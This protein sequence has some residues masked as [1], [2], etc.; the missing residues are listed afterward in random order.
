VRKSKRERLQQLLA[1]LGRPVEPADVPGLAA[2]LAPISAAYLRRLL[3]DSGHPLHP[4]VEGVRQE[5]LEDLARTLSALLGEY[6]RGNAREART[7][8]IEART[9]ARL[10]DRRQPSPL[11]QEAILWMTVWLENPPVFPAWLA[12]RR[13]TAA[14]STPPSPDRPPASQ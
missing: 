2:A 14:R 3:R 6:Q 9:H 1:R 10:A 5:S 13:A 8:V 12:L 7:C 11:R 4:L